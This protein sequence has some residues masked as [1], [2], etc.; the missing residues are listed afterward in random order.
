[1]VASTFGGSQRP[2]LVALALQGGGAIG[3]YHVG[4]FRALKEAGFT[5]D[6]VT[7]VS[8]GTI[9][10]ALIAGNEPHEQ[11]PR[12]EEFWRLVS[13]PAI[14]EAFVPPGFQRLYNTSSA[15]QSLLFGQPN[16]SRPF[17]INP[18]FAPPGTPPA[19]GIYDNSPLRATLSRLVNL[20]RI[21]NV[22]TR[23]SVGVTQVN[24]G[25]AYYFDNNNE[26]DRPFTLNNI[27]ASSAIPPLYAGVRINGELYWDGGIVDNTPLD[28]VL[29]DQDRHPERDALVFMVDLWSINPEEPRTIDEVMWRYNEIQFASRTD[30][31]IK[32]HVERQ[33]LR[34]Q[35]QMIAERV[36]EPERSGLPVFEGGAGTFKFGKLDIV[37]VVY[38]PGVNQTSLS[39]LDFS[40]SSIQERIAAG[41]DDM[42]LVL[43]QAPW[44]EK[45]TPRSLDAAGI[46]QPRATYHRVRRGKIQSVTPG[47]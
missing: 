31:H 14:F 44:L 23:L 15:I 5:P 34:R 22:R 10:A 24:T 37:R 20:D 25:D 29:D 42:K 17:F 41:Y 35:M 9:N 47:M 19:T 45:H 13:D 30:R 36:A 43:E 32:Q 40:N 12:L 3:A 33:N 11:L 18:Y 7:G 4:A 27:L 38:E 2:Q 39:Y 6:W 28:P 21:N 46:A 1:M 26:K 8:I 16:F